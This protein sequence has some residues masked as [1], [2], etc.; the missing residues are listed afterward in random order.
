MNTRVAVATDPLLPN[1]QKIDHIVILMLENRSFDHML[2]YLSLVGGRKDVDGLTGRE[3]EDYFKADGSAHTAAPLPLT[4]TALGLWRDPCHEGSCVAAQVADSGHFVQ[5]YVNNHRSDPDPEVV[6][7]YFSA[8][9]V[10]VYDFLASEFAIGDRWFSSVPGQTWPNRLYLTSGK[11][12]GDLDNR[13]FPPLQYWNHS[14]V[15][16]LDAEGVSWKGYGDGFAGHLSIR[17]SD[18]NYR[19]STHFE[20]FSGPYGFLQDAANGTL[21][22]VSLID[23]V[24]YRNDDHVPAD[25]SAG[26]ALV[27]RTYDAL[28]K[29]RAWSKT[30]LIVLYDEHG[31]FFDHVHPDPAQDDDPLFRRYG[32]RVPA[33]F[34]GPF[35]PKAKC[36]KT[37]WDHASI[38]KTILLRFCNHGGSIPDMGTRVNAAAHLGGVLTEAAARPSVALP[39]AIVEYLAEQQARLTIAEFNEEAKAQQMSPDEELFVAAIKQLQ[40]ETAQAVE[41]SCRRMSE[42]WLPGRGRVAAGRPAERAEDGSPVHLAMAPHPPD[43]QTSVERPDAATLRHGDLVFP[44]N[45]KAVVPYLSGAHLDQA[46]LQK[47]WLAERRAYVDSIRRDPAS[48]PVMYEQAASVE[49]LTYTEFS[50]LYFADM[51]TSDIETM[52]IED[53]F[54]VGHV[55]IVEIAD[56]GTPYVV[57]AM[58][59]GVDK[60]QRIPYADWLHHRPDA[61]IWVA[62]LDLT[63]E[64]K[65][66]FVDRAKTY[67]DRPF[68]FWNFN[69]ADA[70]GFYCSKLV[71][72]SYFKATRV[73]LDGGPAERF[74]WFSPKQ[75]WN[76]YRTGRVVRINAPRNYTY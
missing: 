52:G 75:L 59:S 36:L 73:S 4:D 50:M 9:Q 31:G 26:Q 20:S 10:P 8:A 45:P 37:T 28:A 41:L 49:A 18:A 35:V 57:E 53:V 12:A 24:S 48:T 14:W 71:W 65:Q 51:R 61:W 76:L 25:I 60:V 30:L 23:P 62:R 54:Y 43:P 68:D 11:A 38:V 63:D 22:A 64:L 7:G 58:W 42:A 15:R 33:F 32:V 46:E 66:K 67:L 70:R 39:V 56:D 72:L 69:L 6:M 34:A 1:L 5:N 27:A 17:L 13:W 16:H 55:G 74:L 44:R 29:S 40:A 2:G 21:P 47:R 19:S 3:R